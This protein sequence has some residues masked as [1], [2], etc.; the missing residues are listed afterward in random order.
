VPVIRCVVFDLG[1]VLSSPAG[2]YTEPAA[3]L[4][5]EAS[6]FEALYWRNRVAYD[7]GGS[8]TAYWTPLLTALGKPAPPETVRALAQ[9]D[10][11]LWVEGM[12]PEAL[13]IVR[14]VRKAGRLV[15]MLSNAPFAL[16][17]ALVDAP[18]AGDADY[19]FVSAS[20]GVTKP[21]PAVYYRVEE[22]TELAASEL[23]FIDDRPNNVYGARQAGWEAHLFVD[24]ADTRAWL[25]GLE[26]L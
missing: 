12:R 21:D 9:L 24:D 26:V 20:M 25:R 14:D 3:L 16:D 23:A 7:A 18:Y 2:L 10:A 5:V 8:D 22:V 17:L 13:Q 19:W 11:R 1:Q 4:G 6:A 15:A